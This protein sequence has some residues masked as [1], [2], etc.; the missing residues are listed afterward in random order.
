MM[1]KDTK[2][3]EEY[4]ENSKHCMKILG[5]VATWWLGFVQAWL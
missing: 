1:C 3:P 2:P 4:T 5:T